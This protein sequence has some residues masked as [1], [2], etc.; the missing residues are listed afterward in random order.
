MEPL[1]VIA[2]HVF[3]DPD[4]FISFRPLNDKYLADALHHAHR[5]LKNHPPGLGI[6]LIQHALVDFNDL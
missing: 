5:V 3:K 2:V 4:D 1:D 6:D